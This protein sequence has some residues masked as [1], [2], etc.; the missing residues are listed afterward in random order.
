MRTSFPISASS[1]MIANSEMVG[2]VFLGGLRIIIACLKLSAGS[3]EK[4]A[5]KSTSFGQS[6]SEII[7]APALVVRSFFR[8]LGFVKKDTHFLSALSRE[9]TR[10]ISVSGSPLN[11]KPSFSANSLSFIFTFPFLV[12]AEVRPL[13]PTMGQCMLCY[14]R[15]C[16]K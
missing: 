4:M 3:S 12:L 15:L 5:A 6:F 2:S 9:A 10:S 7:T 14:C 1:A 16:R 8:S 11:F 13:C